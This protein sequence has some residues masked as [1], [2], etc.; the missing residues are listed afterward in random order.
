MKRDAL[1]VLVLI[2]TL[3]CV[4]PVFGQS[5][6]TNATIDQDFCGRSV[7]VIMNSLEGGVNRPQSLARFSGI[8]VIALSD[9]TEITGNVIDLGINEIKNIVGEIYE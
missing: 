7:L 8:D 5:F 3:M 4:S 2:L 6:E 1:Y 9:L